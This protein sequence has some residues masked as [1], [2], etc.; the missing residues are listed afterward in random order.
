MVKNKKILYLPIILTLS[1][2]FI[3]PISAHAKTYKKDDQ[4]VI[5][6]PAY[7]KEFQER[8]RKIKR[9]AQ[10]IKEKN[11][12]YKLKTYARQGD[13]DFTDLI[14]DTA[15][16]I[17]FTDETKPNNEDVIDVDDNGDGGVVAWLEDSGKVMKVS[18]QKK[19]QKIEISNCMYLFSGKKNLESIDLTMLDTKDATEMDGMFEGCE[20][21]KTIDLSPLNTDSVE[22]MSGMFE[23]CK[24]L[25]ELDVSYLN[26][27]K[28]TNMFTM[29][30]ECEG[31]KNLDVSGFDTSK[32]E[33]MTYM[34]SSCKSLS[35]LDLSSFDT[36]NVTDISGITAKQESILTGNDKELSRV[37]SVCIDGLGPM[38][39][40]QFENLL[41]GNKP[42]I[43]L[44]KRTSRFTDIELYDPDTIILI[45][46]MQYEGL[47][48][49]YEDGTYRL[50]SVFLGEVIETVAKIK[51]I[52]DIENVL[53]EMVD[54]QFYADTIVV[55]PL[56]SKAFYVI[57]SD[58]ASEF[59]YPADRKKPAPTDEERRIMN[60]YTKYVNE[61]YAREVAGGEEES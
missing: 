13:K 42:I 16:S 15:T 6:N 60:E 51:N 53:I 17:I 41:A 22:N 40:K 44:Y 35:E 9:K 1:I 28:V 12:T 27:S 39:N 8:E 57:R 33:D 37:L 30:S 18:T 2:G 24:S 56:S 47:S 23:K 3:F 43:D 19:G 52:D 45:P 26:T 29:F 7:T 49:S 38:T 21:L 32:V 48:V 5:K 54:K 20:N 25:T 14:P 36:S 4:I 11:T 34:F 61:F 59:F 58:G 46:S 55:T 10:E 50:N 31:L